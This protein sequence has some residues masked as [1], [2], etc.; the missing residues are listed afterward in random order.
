MTAGKIQQGLSTDDKKLWASRD[1]K[2]HVVLLDWNSPG[3]EPTLNSPMYC[4]KNILVKWDMDVV[5]KSILM[6]EKGFEMFVITYPMLVTNPIKGP[7]RTIYIENDGLGNF[8]LKLF[9]FQN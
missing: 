3:P 5:Y 8:D 9:K 1:I 4:L 2:E 7:P 6:V